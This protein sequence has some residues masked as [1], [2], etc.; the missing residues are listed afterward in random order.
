MS[1]IATG[2]WQDHS[3]PGV[4]AWTLTLTISHGNILLSGLALLVTLAGASFWNITAFVLHSWKSANGDTMHALDLQQRVVLRNSR[5]SLSTVWSLLK[6]HHAWSGADRPGRSRRR[7]AQT[8]ALVAPAVLVWAGFVAAAIFTACLANRADGTVVAPVKAGD[9]GVWR[10]ESAALLTGAAHFRAASDTTA[11]RSYVS[12][13]YRNQSSFASGSSA[14][15]SR[16]VQPSLPI[17]TTKT[18]ACPIPARDRC[19]L[20][21]DGAFGMTTGLLDSHEM[22]GI[23]AAPKDRVALQLSVTCSPVSVRDFVQWVLMNDNRTTMLAFFVGNL[24]E[25]DPAILGYDGGKLDPT[26]RGVGHLHHN[27]SSRMGVDYISLSYKAPGKVLNTTLWEPIADFVRPDADVTLHILSQ[28]S[29]MYSSPV[30]DPWFEA[31]G[32]RFLG[33]F[34]LPNYMTSVM[35]C[36]DQYMLCNPN[37]PNLCSASGGVYALFD[38]VTSFLE[39]V[40]GLNSDTLGGDITALGDLRFNQRQLATA[41]RLLDL[42]LL[43][44]TSTWRSVAPLGAAAL[45]ATGLVN[46]HVSPALPET[47]WQDEV[48]GWFQ[49]TLAK[50]QA[51]VVD[52]PDNPESD[53]PG[54]GSAVLRPYSLN[55]GPASEA[56]RE[57]DDWWVSMCANQLVRTAGEVQ[58]FTFFGVVLVVVACAVLMLLDLMLERLVELVFWRWLRRGPAARWAR[59]ARQARQAD[60]QLQLLRRALSCPCGDDIDGVAQW[61]LGRWGIPVVEGV[62]G[63]QVDFRPPGLEQPTSYSWDARVAQKSVS[64]TARATNDSLE[65]LEEEVSYQTVAASKG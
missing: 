52:Y 4:F 57:F 3:K 19:V 2:V 8:C 39:D 40:D 49:T 48:L 14:T 59:Q 11:A 46:Q 30:F 1:E 31:N 6:L 51:F 10:Y 18:A 5:T 54:N 15:R 53:T 23:N 26:L 43:R 21:E 34:V 41:L 16:F 9:C 65:V 17:H 24:S 62:G 13:F 47:Q 44:E 63:G 20:G 33:S 35:V 50:L 22:L 55:V 60:E 29:V 32:S 38:V 45:W 64:Q 42:V 36:T 25:P 27:E 58:N 12:A 7:R 56:T 37:R 28:N 61:K